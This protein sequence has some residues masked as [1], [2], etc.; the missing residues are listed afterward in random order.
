M[1]LLIGCRDQASTTVEYGIE[2]QILYVGNG[3]EPA[4]LDPHITTG[5]TEFNIHLALFEGLVMLDGDTLQP[6]PGVAESWQISDDQRTYTFQLNPQ[7]RWSNGDPMDA[8]DFAFSIERMLS[9]ELGAEYASTLFIIKN[10]APFNRGEI[11]FSDVGVRV[12]SDDK[13]EITLES[14][15]PYFLTLLATPPLF[16]VHKET[17]LSFGGMSTRA[18]GWTHKQHVGNGPFRLKKWNVSD[19]VIVEKNPHYW[20]HKKVRLQEIHFK[21]IENQSTEERFF[22][23]GKLHVTDGIPSN[24]IPT[25]LEQESPYLRISSELATYFYLFNT[26]RPPL[27]DARVRKALNLAI[28]RSQISSAIRQRNEPAAFHLTPL[29]IGDYRPPIL[30]SESVE[31][32]QALLAEAGFPEGKGFPELT[33]LYNTSEN[34]RSIAEAIQQ[35]WRENLGIRVSLENKEWKVYLAARK[36]GDFDICRAGWYADFYD[37]ENFLSLFSSETGLNHSNWENEAFDS[38]LKEATYAS[39]AQR[40]KLFYEAESILMTEVPFMPIHFYNRAILIH[41]SVKNW[42]SNLLSQRLYKEVYLDSSYGK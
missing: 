3:T 5:L 9:Q 12:L 29:G 39:L 31:S 20:D 41:P 35:M 18:T 19:A 6:V 24:K 33:L 42:H 4:D 38:L 21:G 15:A 40:D 22:R 26:Q 1:L 10:A 14:V 13:L 25:Y 7:A 27:D 23:T 34:H 16:P 11:S 32:A 8:D 37:P 36:A 28:N 2:K 17:I 30:F